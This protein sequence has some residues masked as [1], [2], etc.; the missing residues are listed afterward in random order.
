MAYFGKIEN[1]VVVDS[2]RI[3]QEVLNTGLWGDPNQWIQTSYN[4][5]GGIYYLPNTEPP[6]PDPDQS[7]ALRANYAGIGH[8][9]DAQNDVFHAPR[10]LDINGQL[11][12]SWSIGSPTWLWTPPI[13]YPDDEK[14]YA[15]DESTKSW[16]C[17]DNI[18]V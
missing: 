3:D 14:T 15:W 16:V 13:P 18:T 1:G 12:E 11:C 6:T 9:Y 8:I 7:K 4:T 2:I 5:R 17:I 10:P